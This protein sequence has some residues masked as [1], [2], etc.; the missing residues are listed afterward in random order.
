MVVRG[1]G[2]KK[3][4]PRVHICASSDWKGLPPLSI[5]QEH[6][7]KCSLGKIFFAWIAKI[8]VK[9]SHFGGNPAANLM[10]HLASQNQLVVG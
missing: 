8:V 4:G 7:T 9:S 10:G 1:L 5:H 6:N 2:S 3:Y